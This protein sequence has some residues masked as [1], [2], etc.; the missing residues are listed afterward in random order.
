MDA[1]HV[2]AGFDGAGGGDG[3]VH[4]AGHGGEDLHRRCG[5]RPGPLDDRADRLDEGVDVGGGAGVAEREAQRAP[6][7]LVV[8]PIASST[9][10]GCGYAGRARRAGGALDAAGVEQ[11]QQRV[12]L[13]AREAQVGVAGQAARA[14]GAPFRRASGTISMTRRTRS[15]RSAATRSACSGWC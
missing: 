11:H 5:G 10:L 4:A 13:A 8:A 2:V 15:S 6:G 9:W 1:G 12:A 7:L 3:G 14:G